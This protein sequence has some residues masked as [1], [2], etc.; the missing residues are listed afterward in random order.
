MRDARV[1]QLRTPGRMGR[2]DGGGGGAVGGALEAP[3]S[4]DQGLSTAGCTPRW[5]HPPQGCGYRGAGTS[6][7]RGGLAGI[8][9]QRGL[10]GGVRAGTRFRLALC[11]PW[12]STACLGAGSSPGRSAPSPPRPCDLGHLPLPPPPQPDGGFRIS[13]RMDRSPS[14]AC[15]LGLVTSPLCPQ[16]LGRG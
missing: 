10:R 8:G 9:R 5:N 4:G 16:L 14:H 11:E 12:S 6:E 3:A 13:V 15:P 2:G 1:T 7:G